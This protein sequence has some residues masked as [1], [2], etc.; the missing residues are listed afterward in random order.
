MAASAPGLSSRCARSASWVMVQR[1]RE[2][3]DEFVD[4]GRGDMRDDGDVS[5]IQKRSTSLF[6]LEVAVKGILRLRI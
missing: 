5:N 2:V 6:L 4:D 1:F 3:G